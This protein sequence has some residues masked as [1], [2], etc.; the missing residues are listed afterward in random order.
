MMELAA[1]FL[2]LFISALHIV[3]GEK[4]PLAELSRLTS[5][6]VLIGSVRVMSLQGGV[7]LFAV[8]MVHVLSFLKIFT[9]SGMAVFFPVGIVG[10]NLVTFLFVALA[11]HRKLFS[12]IIF[13][14]ILFGVILVLQILAVMRNLR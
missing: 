14:L 10:L 11:K 5:D 12:I 1:G 6:S 13:Q 3:Y 8:G 4:K 9:L 7:L 2:L